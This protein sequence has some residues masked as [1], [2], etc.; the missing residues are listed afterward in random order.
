MNP[1]NA[2]WAW[3]DAS[4]T[5]ELTELAHACHLSEAD[6]LELVQYGALTPLDGAS[7]KRRFS[8]VWVPPLRKA[9][10]LRA[11]FELDL[12]AVALLLDQLARVESL[13]QQLHAL[14]ARVPASLLNSA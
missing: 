7:E 9:G 13:Q 4:E 11:D 12:L 3:L 2:T 8:A 5:L 14:Q 1:E 6:L 10:R